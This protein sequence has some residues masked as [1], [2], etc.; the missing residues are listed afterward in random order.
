MRKTLLIIFIF[1]ASISTQA[2]VVLPKLITN[3]MILQ[4]NATITIWGWADKGEEIT[5][6]FL[7]HNK[8][9]TADNL[10][11][12]AIKLD[13]LK[14][15]GPYAMK[16]NGKN[17]IIIE[18]I[19]VG[20]V[21]LCA[22]QSNMDIEMS[23]VAPLYPNEIA[24]AN[25]TLIR[26]FRVGKT[27]NYKTPQ[28][29]VESGKW[30]TATQENILS[31]SAVAYFFASQLHNT[32]NV[33]IGVIVNPVGG[34]PVQSWLCDEALKKF[35]QDYSEAIKLKQDNYIDSIK[36]HDQKRISQWFGELASKDLGYKSAHWSK[37]EINFSDWTE[38]EVPSYWN[39]SSVKDTCGAVWF[40]KEIIIP[41]QYNGKEATLNLGTIVDSDSAWINGVFVGNTSYKYP[42]RRYNVPKGLLKEG[43]N[44][45]T[46]RIV[47]ENGP[48]GFTADKNIELKIQKYS[49]DL[50]GTWKYKYGAQ[51]KNLNP[52]TY[53]WSK[54]LGLYNGMISPILP[55]AKKGV[56]WYQGESNVP[57]PDNYYELLTSLI[58]NWRDKFN[59]SDLPFIIIQISNFNKTNDKPIEKSAWATIRD[60]QLKAS[61]TISN[62]ALVTTIDIGEWN[63]IHPLNKKDVGIRSS[64]AAMKIAYMND[65]IV[66]SG[67]TYKNMET[68]GDKII[69]YFNNIGS[70]L[71]SSNGKLCRFQIAGEDKKFVWAD[72]VIEN[73]TVVV[74]SNKIKKPV[75]VRYAWSDNPEGANLYNNEGLPAS[76]FKTD[77]W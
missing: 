39:S 60:A 55:Y 22:G 61:Q 32:Y 77:S 19:L 25:N 29:D 62:T 6:S 27:Y 44:I 48:G 53:F 72:A 10:G 54:P 49:I 50:S 63:D 70:G 59:Q 56:L 31:F 20:E 65:S 41:K 64:L 35:P 7:N 68:N 23:R 13:N 36:T 38:T 2:N 30:I 4:R 33:P 71:K 42:P 58:T 8:Q 47:C 52:S 28:A 16:I 73:N 3:G 67:P 74:S 40:K 11:N 14:A 45:L 75:S 18:D 34:T 9:T 21:W 24:E 17:T 5:L 15:G 37:N 12:W 57:S 43:T 66:Y 51:M 1:I 76:P 46:V 26:Q 69:V